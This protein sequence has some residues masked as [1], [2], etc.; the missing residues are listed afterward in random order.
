MRLQRALRS[1]MFTSKYRGATG[2]LEA[3]HSGWFHKL[4]R[5][6]RSQSS[7]GTT[8]AFRGI[9]MRS[10]TTGHADD[11]LAPSGRFGPR[12]GVVGGSASNRRAASDHKQLLVKSHCFVE[13][14]DA[15]ALV[16]VKTQR[17]NAARRNAARRARDHAIDESGLPAGFTPPCWKNIAVVDNDARA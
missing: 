10:A 12:Y 17:R 11:V 1:A 6:G 5:L 13:L 9:L 7:T 16:V 14:T 4:T 2:T 8:A 3:S 15:D